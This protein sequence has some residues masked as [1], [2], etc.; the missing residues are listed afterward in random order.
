ML[1][2]PRNSDFVMTGRLRRR[3]LNGRICA[4]C[5]KCTHWLC[6]FWWE[7]CHA[8][9]AGIIIMGTTR[10]RCASHT[11]GRQPSCESGRKRHL[12]CGQAS[13]FGEAARAPRAQ[14]IFD[15][16]TTQCAIKAPARPACG[17]AVGR[18]WRGRASMTATK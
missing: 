9:A 5:A 2:G 8:R 4:R 11:R 16:E 6:C 15:D 1:G 10:K 3:G 14:T 12:S 17:A 7:R 18:R 13:A